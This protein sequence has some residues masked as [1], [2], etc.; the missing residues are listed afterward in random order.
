MAEPSTGAAQTMAW[1]FKQHYR[2]GSG[3][4]KP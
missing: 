2:K 4:A 1:P 3:F